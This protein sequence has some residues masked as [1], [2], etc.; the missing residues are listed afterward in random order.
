MP[1]RR[2]RNEA[3]AQLA[4]QGQQLGLDVAGPQGVFGLQRGDRVHGVRATNRLRRGLGQADAQDLAFGDQLG[5]G[6]DGLLDGGVLVDPVLVVEVD[7]VGAQ[8]LQG[9][10]DGGAD[11]GRTAVEQ[12]GS[13][14]G[15]G[16][17]AEFCG[18]D[19]LVAP[20]SN[21]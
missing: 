11:V 6:A 18:E 15:M 19:D 21:A 4:Q 13:V 1:E 5:H 14:P 20:T 8:A 16:Q 7:P 3:D 9:A 2:V 17:D 10:L 12:A